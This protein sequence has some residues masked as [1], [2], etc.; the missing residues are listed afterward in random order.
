MSHKG[1]N[2][3]LSSVAD[4]SLPAV[5]PSSISSK[6]TVLGPDRTSK[7]GLSD[8][9]RRSAGFLSHIRVR[10]L[11]TIFV[12]ILLL[13]G[14]RSAFAARIVQTFYL[15]IPEDQIRSWEMGIAN[16]GPI[17]IY[18]TTVNDV[19]SIT[20]T[21][22]NT[23]I[24]YD[25]W[26]DGYETD[27]SNPKQSTTEV[28]GDGNIANGAPPGCSSNSCDVINAGTVISLQNSVPLVQSAGSYVR[29]QG[30]LYYDARDKVA[31]TGQIVITRSGWLTPT[32]TVLSGAI[33]VLD[34]R[35]WGTNFIV[36]VGVDSDN[37]VV[38][39]MFGYAAV[40]IMASKDATSV[41]VGTNSYT[42]NEG[43]TIY[44]PN[45]NSGTPITSS[46]PVQVDLMTGTPGSY[47]EGR[48]FTLIPQDQWTNSYYSPVS[49]VNG[50]DPAAVLFYNP[51]S[52][53]ITVNV[54]LSGGGTD[55][56]TVPSNGIARYDM[57]QN[58][59]A[60]FYTSGNPAP[61]FFAVFVNDFNNQSYEWASMLIP[62]TSLTPSVVV[63][64]AP[65]NANDPPTSNVDVVWV[66][67][68]AD[69]TIYVNYSGNPAVGPNTD[70]YGNKY[71]V[72]YSVSALD[73][74]RI[75]NPTSYD[76]TG[77]RIYTVD[78]TRIAAFWGEDAS[79]GVTGTL[80]M[81]IGTAVLPYPTLTAYKTAALIGDYN[82]NGGIDAGELIEYTIRVHNSGIFPITNIV[83][84]DALDPNVTYV[85]STTG[86]SSSRTGPF[87]AI[88]DNPLGTSP[89]AG[90]FTIV[91]SPGQLNPGQDLYV[92]FQVTVNN[93]LPGGVASL[94][95]TVTA[96]SASLQHTSMVNEIFTNL[97]SSLVEQGALTTVKTSDIGDNNSV[98]PGDTINYTVTVTNNSTNPQSGITLNDPLPAGTSYVANSTT[99]TGHLQKYVK[100]EFNQLS[101]ANNDGPQN[102][103]GNWT[104]TDAAGGA[105]SPTAGNVQV[106]SGSL[107]LTASGSNASRQADL[108]TGIAGRNYT[109]A[110][111]TFDYRTSP[112]VAAA[113]AVQV[114]ASGN[115]HGWTTLGTL[116][117][118]N[119]Q[120]SGSASYDISTYIGADT[121]IRFRLSN[122]YNGDY[123]YADN[124]TVKTNEL[125]AA[126]TKDNTAAGS[127]Y[128]TSGV[129]ATLMTPADGFSL[130]PGQ[131]LTVTYSLQVN[132][133]PHA[134]RVTNTVSTTSYEQSQPAA[135]TTIN[136]IDQGGAIGGRVWLDSVANGVVD[137]GE[138]GL[139][140]IPVTLRDSGNN[141]VAQTRTGTDGTYVF[142]GLAIGTY[143][144]SVDTPP[145]GL[146]L[147]TASNPISVDLSNTVL[148]PD[149]KA[150]G[151]NFG[152]KNGSATTAIVGD[153]V[154]SDAD[155]NGI[156][157]PGEG[158]LGGVTMQLVAP[159]A[160]GVFGTADDVVAASTTTNAFGTYLFTNVAPGTYTV[161][162]DT[163]NIL[164][165]Y[166]STT[167]PQSAV[168]VAGSKTTNAFSVIG[169]STYLMM[170]FGFYSASTYSVSDKVWFDLNDN[171]SLDPGEPGIGGITVSL[172]NSG[173]DVTAATTSDAYGNF[174]FSGV[175][176]GQDYTVKITDGDQKLIGFS[177]TTTAAQNAQ[178]P[179]SVNN[180]DVSGT[181]FGYNAPGRIGYRVWNDGNGN[182]V[183]DSGEQGMAGVILSLYFDTNGDGILE[184]TGTNPDQLV[185]T[186]TTDSSGDY[187]FQ[188]TSGGRYFVSVAGSQ[189][190]L[191]GLVLT[192]TDD[193]PVAGYQKTITLLDLYTSDMTANFGF[194][195]G[196]QISSTVWN[197]TNADGLMEAGEQGIPGV[198]VL[199]YRS[200]TAS[201]TFDPATDTLVSTATTD[202]SGNYSFDL[203]QLGTGTGYYFV[204]VD[205]TQS[206]LA[207]MTLTTSDDQAAA[208]VQQTLDVTALGANYPGAKFG[209]YT[210]QS[211]FT[212]TKTASPSGTVSPGQTITYTITVT[213]N[214]STT[215]TG[216]NVTDPLPANTTYVNGSALVTGYT[217]G[218]VTLP[219]DADTYLHEGR[220]ANTNYGADDPLQVRYST[221]Y[222]RRALVHFDL[223][224]IPAGVT[225]NSATMQFNVSGA[226]ANIT[227][228]NLYRLTRAWGENT[229]TWNS[230]WTT[231]GG[232][233][234]TGTLIGSFVPA[235]T[236]I[237]TVSTPNLTS[238][239]GNWYSGAASNDGV[240]LVAQAGGTSNTASVNSR[241]NGTAADRPGLTV[242]YSG[243]IN[244][245]PSVTYPSGST[246]VPASDG[247]SLAPGQS[248]TI[249]YDVT[250]GG[251]PDISQLTNIASV[252]SNQSSGPAKAFV[253]NAMYYTSDLKVTKTVQS[254]SSPCNPGTCQVSYLI[255]VANIGSLDESNVN[256]D[257]VLPAGLT[258]LSDT[259]GQGSYDS[260][261][262][263]WNVGSLAASGAVSLALVA[264]VNDTSST[265]QNCASLDTQ[266]SPPSPADL[267]AGNNTSCASFVPT[268][269]ALS[270]FR[271]FNVNGR[272][273]VQWTT[274]SENDTAGFYLF[275]RD[276]S[277]GRYIQIDG[278]ILP[279]LI[280]VPQGGT[281]GLV[282]NGAS[283]DQSYTYVLVEV[284]GR[285][286][287]LAYGPFTVSAGTVAA[288]NYG[289]SGSIDPASLFGGT[290]GGT[291]EKVV[292]SVARDGA[293]NI[294]IRNVAPE[295]GGGDLYSGYT[296][297]A[298]GMSSAAGTRLKSFDI[299]S[300]A[301]LAAGR[302]KVGN[303]L[304]ISVSRDGLYS[305]DT[306][307]IADLLGMNRIR[308]RMMLRFGRLVLSNMGRS[309]AYGRAADYSGLYFY[310]QRIKSIYTRENVYWLAVG[311][312]LLMQD[313]D[314]GPG[315]AVQGDEMFTTSVHAEEDKMAVPVLFNDPEADF[316]FWDSVDSGDPEYGSRTFS[317]EADGVADTSAPATLNVNLQGFT[318]TGVSPEH[319]AVI[320]LNGVQIGEGRWAGTD[321]QTLTMNFDQSLLHEGTNTVEV[322]GVL[323]TGAPYSIFMVKSFDLTYK[324][325]Y[326][327]VGNA[328]AFRGDSNPAVTVGGFTDRNISLFDVTDSLHPRIVGS[329][330][331]SGSGGDFS[332]SFDPA[333]PDADYYAVSDGAALSPDDVRAETAPGLDDRDNSAD[334]LIITTDDLSAAAGS[335]AAYR[336][337]QGYTPKI[338][339]LDDIMD[340]FNYGI[341]SPHAV[342]DF[343]SYAYNNWIKPPK[344]VLLAGNG[345]YDYKDY[346][347][348]GDNL[349]P[350]LMTATPMGLYSSDTVFGEVDQTGVPR[351]AIGRLPVLTPGELQDAIA[352]IKAY[353][354]STG[355]NILMLADNPDGGGDFTDDSSDIISLIP[356]RYNVKTVYLSEYP[357][358]EARG[359]L[360]GGI[361]S[362]AIL[363]NY[364]GHGGMDRL[365]YDSSYGGLL[366]A[367][368]VASLSNGNKLPVV[369][370]MT[371]S[372]GQFAEPGFDS[373]AE[374]LVLRK[375]GGAAA[376][377]APTGLALDSLSRLLDEGFYGAV[378]EQ[379]NEVLGDVVLEALSRYSAA[380]GAP[381]TVNIYNLLGDPALRMKM[382]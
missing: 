287:K 225:I 245:A 163:A 102:W 304:R 336:K 139:Y 72:S 190:P 104:E 282:D 97:Q 38:G 135:Y 29:D 285:G 30:N 273:A 75:N 19:I 296:R 117:G 187:M 307:T 68:A 20:A 6:G 197:D 234:D 93:P 191:S 152:Y 132:D 223:S 281:Y 172:L 194:N 115:G 207:T 362:G 211:D 22:D 107:R 56:V 351:I 100:D 101:Y 55:T 343:L 186:T 231:A 346:L 177:G 182:G 349:V 127:S 373:L 26:E 146:A 242:S 319:H 257:D 305:L 123:F 352:K 180:A 271:A 16:S 226:A 227:S 250:V 155:D 37:G 265:I 98:K 237:K 170:D 357:V 221:A 17:P 73:S 218:T 229:A 60:H 377:W 370:A 116:T 149:N 268:K 297:E 222:E 321:P 168:S 130:A 275:R 195:G 63:G 329:A 151:I 109:S 61:D 326:R 379:R 288:G 381:F 246:L 203:N 105:Q 200:S 322:T 208:G 365:S 76:M 215:Q 53:P 122:G 294:T 276:D 293:L 202:S 204:S 159:G 300:A 91:S 137:T 280:S 88:A 144:V 125:A 77:A 51:G 134:T 261:T 128:L 243:I 83:L 66:T 143:S 34:T 41:Q 39:T 82:S 239:V 320:S 277:T 103:N 138:P 32:G 298:N 213:N 214:S 10:R 220:S 354:G 40:S 165:G 90:G 339:T 183:Q 87:T 302:R 62:E 309:V 290:A 364:F 147:S 106:I 217:S 3:L 52:S 173:G 166:T 324:R 376:V 193:Q 167:G 355:N 266:T 301:L 160:D 25:Q 212:V 158:G 153:Y 360:S 24:Y 248:M 232:D 252:S 18:D 240:I 241:E 323:D 45:I 157:D 162:A 259:P 235:T 80:G 219:D 156:Q 1:Q 331:V 11:I 13:V 253:T 81:D 94:K 86:Y 69:T 312:G 258:Y 54:A 9:F 374:T 371:C 140:N 8:D 358:N 303:R 112:T 169:G 31:A 74:L 233:Y 279:A 311:K 249:T 317:V 310:G 181:H 79:T 350:P 283:V 299:Q 267:N 255:T 150:A 5:L 58:T 111:L 33:E 210:P 368:D 21:M 124:V 70:P 189:A 99:A 148:Y 256:V 260:G 85:A 338:V 47:Y 247:F 361:D 59:G 333:S 230:P 175:A 120:T 341:Y 161:N 318:S 145:S 356:G 251:T 15:P 113:D 196:G 369:T 348:F 345:T 57:P 337:G 342:Q 65:G 272:L 313:V 284:E 49:T 292:K 353:E 205:D 315:A 67:P 344:Y 198:T 278:R 48:W 254:Y 224:A 50:A 363:I 188:V 378:F 316:W 119:G 12:L 44:I 43:E 228:I 262:G 23:I 35:T 269:V 108:T 199:L 330:A 289:V 380:G 375:D 263:V 96:T 176:G 264:T 141:V 154:W 367:D 174:T 84:T 238:L 244:R 216:I 110:T 286:A 236:G 179:V 114:Q 46:A 4:P 121:A 185:D 340:E 209:F 335:L 206:A 42:L 131:T 295:T 133:P 201:S 2:P 14:I 142:S 325:L 192:T 95:N 7:N 64:W 136:P 270:A 28:W 71:D 92:Q 359:L 382:W 328:L 36:P 178:L 347:G 274:V 78:G 366:T 372:A 327:A 306:S 334:Y 314:G 129:P 118:F 291:Q 332:V 171:G 126:V 164:T 184:T 308:V 89:L 27:I